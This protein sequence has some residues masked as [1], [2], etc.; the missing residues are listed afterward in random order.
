MIYHIA[1]RQ[2]WDD[3]QPRGAYH[4]AS[5]DKEGFIH[6]STATQVL[7]VGNAFYRGRND[8]VLLL[9]DESKLAHELKWEAP[10]GPPA[11]GISDSDKF[12]HVFG[13]INF[14]AIA[15]VLDF[16]PDPVSGTFTLP[17]H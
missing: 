15:S 3:S 12:P 9:I 8:L 6:C 11:S 13:P 14:S 10:A 5:L 7:H 2:D 1:T 4:T 16:V 17:K